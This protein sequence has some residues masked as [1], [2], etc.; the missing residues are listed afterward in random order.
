MNTPK[1]TN[2]FTEGCSIQLTGEQTDDLLK[3]ANIYSASS[4]EF[5]RFALTFGM[6]TLQRLWNRAPLKRAEALELIEW[7]DGTASKIL[8]HP[9]GNVSL[10]EM[11]PGEAREQGGA[12]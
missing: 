10:V 9:N 7:P 11:Q 5:G 1:T 12:A 6:A 3:T 2:D 4:A 8:R